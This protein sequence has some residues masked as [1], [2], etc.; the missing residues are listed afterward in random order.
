MTFPEGV[1]AADYA[2]LSDDLVNL[3][4]KWEVEGITVTL[5]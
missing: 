2:G 5:S 4:A 3:F 1:N